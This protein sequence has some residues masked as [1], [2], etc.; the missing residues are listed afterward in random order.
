MSPA[1][2]LALSIKAEYYGIDVRTLILVGGILG[3]FYFLTQLQRKARPILFK[4]FVVAFSLLAAFTVTS[5]VIAGLSRGQ[6]AEALRPIWRL[7]YSIANYFEKIAGIQHGPITLYFRFQ[8]FQIGQTEPLLVA[9]LGRDVLLVHY[10]SSTEAMIS[11]RNADF[12]GQK[13]LPFPIAFRQLHC[14]EIDM[15]AL[16]PPPEHPM[17]DGW[18]SAKIRRAQQICKITLDGVTVIQTSG[19]YSRSD[20]WDRH[21]GTNPFDSAISHKFSGI[22]EKIAQQSPSLFE[23]KPTPKYGP[24]TFDINLPDFRGYTHQPL[25]S[26]GTNGLSD[27]VFITLVSPTQI[28]IGHDHWGA[29][30]VY[31][32]PITLS[33]AK[34]HRIT[35]NMP[36]LKPSAIATEAIGSLRVS[37]DGTYLLDLQRPFHLQTEL[38]ELTL[39]FNSIG[40]SMTTAAFN[41]LISN[42]HWASEH[43]FSPTEQG[44]LRLHLRL[45][46]NCTG[47]SEPL[48]VS[49]SPGRANILFIHYQSPTE[50]YFG[51]DAWGIGSDRSTTL[52]ID[53]HHIQ[54]IEID[55]APFHL[56]ATDRPTQIKLNRQLVFTSALPCFKQLAPQ[57]TLGENKI[58]ASTCE[59]IFTGDIYNQERL[60]TNRD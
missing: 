3:G 25:V 19:N 56:A 8:N 33:P 35:V 2:I 4:I 1:R 7:S 46:Q 60:S 43:P 59:P 13:S 12:G 31:S 15:G 11:Y 5:S 50:I 45:P 30:A 32:E 44:A 38:D 40:S 18:S 17:F 24:L 37:I 21:I 28:S 55:W 52:I 53:P 48:L 54:E 41:G 26:T 34:T 14:L 36:S 47:Q 9:G 23:P 10:L 27:L 16:Y 6:Q 39:G 51:H 57:L 20:R 58:G 49:G 42:I 22:I 29:G